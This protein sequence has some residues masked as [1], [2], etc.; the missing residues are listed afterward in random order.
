MIQTPTIWLLVAVGL[1]L[2]GAAW[3]A[4]SSPVLYE[5]AELFAS[6]GAPEDWFGDSVAIEGDRIV[7]GSRRDDDHGEGSGSVYVFERSDEGEW[8]ETA[9][10]TASDAQIEDQFSTVALSGDTIVVGAEFEDEAGFQAGAAY[11]F[12][13]AEAGL[14]VEATKLRASD[15]V[16]FDVFGRPVVID[17]NTVAI[18][19]TGRDDLG[20]SSGA[21]YVFERDQNGSWKETAKLLSPDPRAF[22][23]FGRVAVDGDLVVVGAE[24][25]NP[26]PGINSGTADLFRRDGAVWTHASRLLPSEGQD[27]DQFGLTTAIDGGTV[28]VG[29]RLSDD[30]GP[31]SGSVYVFGLEECMLRLQLEP[32]AVRVGDEL[33]VGVLLEHNRPETVTVPFRVWIEDAEG[34]VVASRTTGPQTFHHGDSVRRELTL[35]I[36]EGTPPGGYRVFVGAERMQQ[37]LAGAERSFR[38]L[39]P[40]PPPLVP[41]SR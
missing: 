11:I 9:K 37:G 14:W 33:R 38:V 4:A 24:G 12:E 34:G 19:A 6:D 40:S 16:A 7:V 23:S 2:A 27:Q 10:L 8:V 41:P 35:R 25:G 1:G 13:R 39:G 18:G 5:E 26:M 32:A 36:P 17:G 22:D 29:A 15:G 20:V 31:D 30:R 3:T 21:A 28:V